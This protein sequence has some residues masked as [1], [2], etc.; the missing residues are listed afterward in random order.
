MPLGWWRMTDLKRLKTVRFLHQPV[1]SHTAII[2][3]KKNQPLCFVHLALNQ[4]GKQ[5]EAANLLKHL[6]ENA[7]TESR[8]IPTALVIMILCVC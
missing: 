5:S 8:Y 2:F 3:M 1:A 6:A 7:V 4:A